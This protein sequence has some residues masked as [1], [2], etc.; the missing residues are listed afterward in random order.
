M[1]PEFRTLSPKDE[2]S[3]A[4]TL[5]LGGWQQ[6]FPVLDQGRVVGMLLRT[7]MIANLVNGDI[8]ANVEK[9]LRHD[10][11][12]ASPTEPLESLYTRSQQTEVGT[13]PI[14]E[15]GRLLGL[16]KLENLAAHMAVQTAL[17]K[18]SKRMGRSPI[19]VDLLAPTER[20]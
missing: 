4:V 11:P 16:V 17:T 1:I 8:R 13:V 18:A 19:R 3:K 12:V 6:D 7:D 2:L 10:F 14:I 15:N 5:V 9:A 20:A